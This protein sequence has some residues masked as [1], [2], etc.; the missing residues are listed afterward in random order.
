MIRSFIYYVFS[1]SL[2]VS[3]TGIE[4]DLPEDTPGDSE[5]KEALSIQT[6]SLREETKAIYEE[7][8]NDES[9][10]QVIHL[11]RFPLIIISKSLLSQYN[12]RFQYRYFR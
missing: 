1:L 11:I 5:E 12:R 4:T 6:L 10:I 3:C 7:T 8:G 2:L 9:P